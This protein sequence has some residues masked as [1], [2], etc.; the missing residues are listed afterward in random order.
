MKNTLSELEANGNKFAL[1]KINET[2]F[3]REDIAKKAGEIYSY[4]LVNLTE[5]TNCCEITV[6][7]PAY[8]QYNRVKN[9]ANFSEDELTETELLNGGDAEGFMYI[10]ENSSFEVVKIW[11]ESVYAGTD[12]TDI[13]NEIVEYLQSNPIE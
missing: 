3:W 9:T 2:R 10:R 8:W 11:S 5:P 4:Y 13:E 12:E 1:V 6:S 7:F